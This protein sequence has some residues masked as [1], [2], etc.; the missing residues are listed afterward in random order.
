[1]CIPPAPGYLAGVKDLC[2]RHGAV[3]VVDEVI[4]GFRLSLSGAQ[5]AFGVHGDVTIFAKAMGAG[6][7]IAAIGASTDLLAPVADGTVNHS[8]TYNT[9]L[10]SVA[11][12]VASLDEL[13][14][15]QPHD[16]IART[17]R[18]L[19][20]ALAGL[21]TRSGHVLRVDGPG[22]MVQLRFGA[23]AEPSSLAGFRATGDPDVL[24]S[25]LAA[26]QDRGV[27]ATS[28]GMCFLSSAHSD[29]DIDRAAEA[30]RAALG[31]I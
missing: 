10:S 21:S 30:A 4:T 18:S 8:G 19:A 23:E 22:P 13:A 16:R 17:G 25:F 27:R 7:P 3:W 2:A 20:G 11:A 6:F 1:G 31:E 9:G 28:R 14:A 26:W 24:R 29:D 12:A 15:S 5:G